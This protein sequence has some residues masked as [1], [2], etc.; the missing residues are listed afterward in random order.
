MTGQGEIR[1]NFVEFSQAWWAEL[2][3]SKGVLN[4]AEQR[5]FE[6]YRRLVSLNAWRV[7]LIEGQVSAASFSF[8]VEAQNDALLSHIQ[9][10]SGGWRIGLQCLRSAIE[11]LLA[12]LFYKDHPIELV[13]WGLG[14]HRQSA[15]ELLDYVDQLP[16]LDGVPADLKGTEILRKEYATLSMAV[17]ASSVGFRMS[18]SGQLPALCDPQLEKLGMWLARER[19]TLLGMNMLLLSIY[20]SELQGAAH[21]GLRGALGYVVPLGKHPKIRAELRVSL[22]RN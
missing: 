3:S 22:S 11:N 1:R 5:Y 8:F 21:R 4:G 12:F 20:R 13:Q 19:K 6:S 15:R 18:A 14:R 16:N 17:H 7:G 10:R 2:E 9:A